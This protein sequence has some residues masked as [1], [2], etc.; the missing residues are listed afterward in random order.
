[1]API[2]KPKEREIIKCVREVIENFSDGR[3][4]RDCEWSYGKI[5]ELVDSDLYDD[6]LIAQSRKEDY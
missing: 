4:F 1:M 5:Y 3:E 2:F 6:Y